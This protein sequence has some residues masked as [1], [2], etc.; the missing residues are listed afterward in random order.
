MVLDSYFRLCAGKVCDKLRNIVGLIVEQHSKNV[1]T[2]TGVGMLKASRFVNEYTQ[3]FHVHPLYK[4]KVAGIT[5]SHLREDFPPHPDDPSLRKD[6]RVVYQTS[7]CCARTR[8]KCFWGGV[9]NFANVEMLPVP[10]LPMANG[11]GAEARWG[12]AGV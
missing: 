3:L 6:R 11:A 9:V 12:F 7:V 2:R 4:E 8:V 5:S 10:M 1:E